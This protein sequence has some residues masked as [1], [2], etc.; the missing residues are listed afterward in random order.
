MRHALFVLLMLCLPACTTVEHSFAGR[1]PNQVWTA[2]NAVAGG[3]EYDDWYVMENN[4][5]ADPANWRIEV[6]RVLRRDTHLPGQDPKREDR[7]WRFQVVLDPAEPPTATFTSRGFGIPMQARREGDRF[8]T[9]VDNLLNAGAIGATY[10][11]PP[12]PATTPIGPIMAPP[13]QPFVQ[14]EPVPIDLDDAL[15]PPRAVPDRG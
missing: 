10:Q 14:P 9:Q 11:A 8:F 15:E 2:L 12:E 3:P 7:H 1:D 6:E 4:L 13:N 5:W